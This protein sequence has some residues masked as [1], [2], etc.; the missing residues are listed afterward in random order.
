MEINFARLNFRLDPARAHEAPAAKRF[1]QSEQ[2]RRHQNNSQ[3]ENVVHDN[4]AGDETQR[5]DDAAR[6]A[7]AMADIGSKKT[8]HTEKIARCVPKAKSCVE[9]MAGAYCLQ[10]DDSFVNKLGQLGALNEHY[11]WAS[12]LWGTIAGGYLVYGWKQKASIPLV[13]GA[14]MT[15]ATFVI[16]SALW[17][18][19]VSI[20]IMFAVWWLLKQGY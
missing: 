19:V 13:G 15:V 2:A 18:S 8:I 20:A 9:R 12:F 1:K 5:A 3:P 11:I 10:M 14:V 17:L 6:D 4:D 7:S 16:F